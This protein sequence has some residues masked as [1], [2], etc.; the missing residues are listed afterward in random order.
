MKVEGRVYGTEFDLDDLLRMDTATQVKTL[1]EATRGML[2]KPDEARRKLGFGKVDGGDA[3]YAQQ[4][5]FSLAAL[6]KRDQ[7][8][9]FAKPDAPTTPAPQ[10]DLQPQRQVSTLRI[11]AACASPFQVEAA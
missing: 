6:A 8:D 2:M 7:S 4:Q 1:S 5:D 10:P 11:K 3:V 9:P